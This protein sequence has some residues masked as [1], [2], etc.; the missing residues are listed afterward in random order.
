M[1]TTPEIRLARGHERG[2]ILNF[3]EAMGFNPRDH[4]TWDALEMFTMSAWQGGQLVGTIPLE[5]RPLR[6]APQQT[7]CGAHEPVVAVL[8]DHRNQGI[9]SA[10]QP[11]P[12]KL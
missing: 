11:G 10:M 12:F 3:V 4:V 7:L 6:I 1:T 8:P 9:A 5:P 2:Q